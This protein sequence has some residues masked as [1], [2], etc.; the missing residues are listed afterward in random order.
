[1]SDPTEPTAPRRTTPAALARDLS[2]AFL[3]REAVERGDA[4]VARVTELAEAEHRLSMARVQ[5]EAAQLTAQAVHRAAIRAA[6]EKEARARA[7]QQEI[8]Q[9]GIGVLVGLGVVVLLLVAMLV[10]T[11]VMA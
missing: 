5:D 4:M 9:V 8:I 11:L 2:T 1:M 6:A 10:G 7:R 3:G